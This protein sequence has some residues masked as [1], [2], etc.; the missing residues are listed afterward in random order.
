V[1][2]EPTIEPIRRA[3]L[4]QEVA[5][6]VRAIIERDGLRPGDRLMP[7]RQLAEVLG[8][9]RTSIRQALAAL[10]AVGLVDIRHGD[11]VYLRSAPHD[12]RPE[13]DAQL[14]SS[15]GVLVGVM[16][17]REALEVQIARL[18][19]AR[20]T[21]ADLAALRDAIEA[22]GTAIEAG[23]DPAASDEQFHAA[24]AAAAGN[25]MLLDLMHQIAEPI[26]LTRRA[27]LARA[28]QSRRSL[29]GHQ[30]I[31]DAITAGDPDA[32]MTA[33]REHLLAVAA[34]PAPDAG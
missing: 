8:V 33:M 18:A 4:Y 16:E 32:A 27:S 5:Q 20:R 13:I 3:P 30:R 25:P 1:P 24:L 14:H 9:S 12:V 29:D 17:V 21:D 7:E 26:A 6:R 34:P 10:Q 31:L 28:G 23:R 2:P 15:D 22:M 11:G 19:A